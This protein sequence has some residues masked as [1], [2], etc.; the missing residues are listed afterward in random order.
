MRLMVHPPYPGEHYAPHGQPLTYPEEHYAPHGQ[1]LS[2]PREHYAPH[3]PLFP[4]TLGST[5]RLMVLSS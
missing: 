5:M 1:P 4:H 3:G 2:Y